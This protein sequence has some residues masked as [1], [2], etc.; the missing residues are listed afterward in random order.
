MSCLSVLLLR[1]LVLPEPGL[2]DGLLVHPG[3]PRVCGEPG[4]EVSRE[5][6]PDGNAV[7]PA[8][9][10]RAERAHLLALREGVGDLPRGA[11]AH[12]AAGVHYEDLVRHVDL[13]EVHLVEH[14]LRSF[15][16]DLII[17][18]VAEEADGDDDIAF[19]GET[20]LRLHILVSEAGAAAE[21]YHFES[22]LHSDDEVIENESIFLL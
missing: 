12:I 4:A 20:L 8:Q 7:V 11:L 17:A 1:P 22:A 14:L 15:I 21:G 13:A 2:D 3:F 16:P 5:D 19:E 10:E 6:A 18:A 9:V